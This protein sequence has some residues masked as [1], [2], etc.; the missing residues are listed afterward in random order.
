VL[1]GI[2]PKLQKRVIT[3]AIAFTALHLAA[4]WMVFLGGRA[5]AWVYPISG[6]GVLLGFAFMMGVSVYEMWWT[7]KPDTGS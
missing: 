7:F 2:G 4:P 6:A 5:L 3:A 1:C